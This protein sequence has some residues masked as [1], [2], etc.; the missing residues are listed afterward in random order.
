MRL[1]Q[2]RAALG[3]F[4]GGVLG[5]IVLSGVELNARQHG[6][7]DKPA[8]VARAKLQSALVERYR[9]LGLAREI[10]FRRIGNICFGSAWVKLQ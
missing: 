5:C 6:L 1:D 9:L 4:P 3:H 8:R 10:Q 7:E 2:I